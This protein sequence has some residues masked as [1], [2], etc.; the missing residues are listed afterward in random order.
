METAPQPL[1]PSF[2][3]ATADSAQVS[4]ILAAA[5]A[6]FSRSGYA[7]ASMREIAQR[8]GVSK[9]LLHYHFQSKEHLFV[10]VQMHAYDRLA[11]RV[12]AAVA[13]LDGGAERGLAAFDALF[14]TLRENGDLTVQAELWAGALSNA[15]LREH[16]VR[17][18][19]F[20]RDLIIQSIERILG[21]DRERLPMSTE[22][23]ADVIWANLNGLGIVSAFGE[24]GER[25]DRAIQAMR[26]LFVIAL[27]AAPCPDGAARDPMPRAPA[28]RLPAPSSDPRRDQER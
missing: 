20:V 1:G 15:A 10:E 11:A 25:V 21:P 18:R 9:S 27:G 6:C 19:E 24:P 12:T 13:Q 2:K 14:A 17:L 22:L 3:R 16:V 26:Q 28:E 8:A 4:A 7:G 5:E 23:A